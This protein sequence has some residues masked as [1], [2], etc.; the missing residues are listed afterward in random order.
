[1]QKALVFDQTT[2]QTI[3]AAL[4]DLSYATT[5]T[6]TADIGAAVVLGEQ[7]KEYK[8][9]A[10]GIRYFCQFGGNGIAAPGTPAGA[11]AQN[12]PELRETLA[13]TRDELENI[14]RAL[15]YRSERTEQTA[16]DPESDITEE[17]RAL[18]REQAKGYKALHRQIMG[19]LSETEEQNT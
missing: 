14:A 8:A 12:A 2:L 10:N 3:A 6:E 16:A 5:A 11:T 9:T 19:H 4:V 7:A 15:L 18:Y 13:F 1:M 17:T